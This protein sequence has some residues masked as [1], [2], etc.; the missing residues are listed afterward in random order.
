MDRC[1]ASA[2]AI[3]KLRR[4][5]DVLCGR[6]HFRCH[7]QAQQGLRALRRFGS[8]LSGGNGLY[9]CA[10]NSRVGARLPSSC[11]ARHERRIALFPCGHQ[12]GQRLTVRLCRQLT[13]RSLGIFQCIALGSECRVTQTRAHSW[14]RR[15]TV[16]TGSPPVRLRIPVTTAVRARATIIATWTPRASLR[17]PHLP[18]RAASRS[19]SFLSWMPGRSSPRMAT[20]GLGVGLGA[21][22]GAAGASATGST[23]DSRFSVAT[24]F[25]LARLQHLLRAPRSRF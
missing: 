4:V 19:G 21:G 3:A 16:A 24:S 23:E 22:G 9:P 6:R 15:S 17:S 10:A 1:G 25:L 11:T 2:I 12:M 8:C 18:P 5:R 14:P 20:T 7:F 13:Q